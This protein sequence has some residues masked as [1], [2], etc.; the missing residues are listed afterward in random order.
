MSKP[1]TLF[2]YFKKTPKK[3][4]EENEKKVLGTKSSEQQQG[5]NNNNCLGE[6][7]VQGKAIA[8]KHVKGYIFECIVKHTQLSQAT[9]VWP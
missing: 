5:M 9:L 2:S 1:N 4:A 8:K 7:E 3:P 6:N